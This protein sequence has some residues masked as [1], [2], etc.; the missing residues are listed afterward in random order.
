MGC[1]FVPGIALLVNSWLALTVPVVMYILLR[2]MV[3]KEEAYLEER[4]KEEYLAYKRSTPAVL[5]VG[6]IKPKASF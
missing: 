3:R 6:W 5:P 4:F 1:F 2:L